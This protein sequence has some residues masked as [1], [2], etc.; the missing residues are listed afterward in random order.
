[1][2]ESVQAPVANRHSA[3]AVQVQVKPDN[4]GTSAKNLSSATPSAS[5]RIGLPAALVIQGPVFE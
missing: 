5:P 1:M 3:Q 4:S 2:R